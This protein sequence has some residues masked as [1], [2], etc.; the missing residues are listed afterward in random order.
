MIVGQELNNIGLQYT[1]M[2]QGL[3]ETIGEITTDQ[4]EIL[5]ANIL[6]SG[7]ELQ[8]DKRNILIEKIKDLVTEMINCPEELLKINYSDYISQKL[9]YDYTYLSN[10]FS[11]VKGITIQHFIILNKIERVKELLL[12]DNLNL[13]EISYKLRYSSV[14]HLSNQFKKIT[15]HSPSLYKQMNQKTRLYLETANT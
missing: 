3:V 10:M 5:R 6:R 7:L 15:G 2:G 8:V 14:A 4:I 13:T 11:K 9:N 1:Y 12:H